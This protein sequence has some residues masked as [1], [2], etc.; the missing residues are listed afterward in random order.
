[1]GK[2]HFDINVYLDLWQ[3][4]SVI[5]LKQFYLVVSFGLWLGAAEF[6]SFS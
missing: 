1:V 5:S 4:D 3:R 2:N 6:N